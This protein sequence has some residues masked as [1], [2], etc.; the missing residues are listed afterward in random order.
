MEV[1]T[2]HGYSLASDEASIITDESAKPAYTKSLHQSLLSLQDCSLHRHHS[3]SSTDEATQADDSSVVKSLPHCQGSKSVDEASMGATLHQNSTFLNKKFTIPIH[4][5]GWTLTE[6]NIL[7]EY[8]GLAMAVCAVGL[9]RNACLAS[10]T[11]NIGFSKDATLSII[12][13][14]ALAPLELLMQSS[15]AEAKQGREIQG[16][17]D[18]VEQSRHLQ[19]INQL[20]E[21]LLELKRLRS[22]DGKAN[23]R[24]VSIFASKEQAWKAER[25]KFRD[26]Q[27]MLCQELQ[28]SYLQQEALSLKLEHLRSPQK[29]PC[30]ECDHREGLF[31]AL[32]GRL[33][34]QEFLI[35]ATME[36]AQIE[37]QEK[38][39]LAEKLASV[40]SSLSQM[41]EKLSVEAERHALELK[42]HGEFKELL[43]IK[44]KEAEI[45]N[46]QVSQELRAAQASISTLIHE[47]TCCEEHIADMSTEVTQLK[48]SV[49][50][51]DDI[52]SAMFKKAKADNEDRKELERELAIMKVK[53]FH[54]EKEKEKWR[55]LAEANTRSSLKTENFRS[56]SG[57]GSRPV[58]NT[59]EMIE[60]LQKLHDV[61]VKSLQ[62]TYEEQV[63]M[64]QKRLSLYQERVADLEEDILSR[65]TDA[66][67]R[68]TYK[69]HDSLNHGE[70]K[71]NKC[72]VIFKES[73][74]AELAT[75]QFQLSVAKTLIKQFMDSETH[76]EQEIENWKN[77]YLASKAA[78]GVHKEQEH[79]GAIV[80]K[81]PKL[82][83]RLELEKSR[84]AF[85][86]EQRH[87]QEIDAFERQMKA[88]DERMEAFRWQ[89]LHMEDEVQMCHR[90]IEDLKQSLENANEENRRLEE[91]L[92]QEEDEFLACQKKLALV[93]HTKCA[94]DDDHERE[95]CSLQEK[96]SVLE[97]LLT[98][99]TMEYERSL[100]RASA[101]AES[102]L[103]DRESKLAAAE[104]QLIQARISF[105]TERKEKEKLLLELQKEKSALELYFNTNLNSE[106]KKDLQAVSCKACLALRRLSTRKHE[107]QAQAS[108]GDNVDE[109][110]VKELVEQ[111]AQYSNSNLGVASIMEEPGSVS[112]EKNEKAYV[113]GK[114]QELVDD[115]LTVDKFVAEV[116]PSVLV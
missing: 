114:P 76:R 72:M 101:E 100:I 67:H 104:A 32:K 28:R 111:S 53:L 1:L 36:E 108:P 74:D 29:Q 25:R 92:K 6:D 63:R 37:Q 15:S 33:G 89:L 73:M 77:L 80:P 91:L 50:G 107:A 79:A 5:T 60:E 95:V 68:I 48:R 35:M 55:R 58:P 17:T 38:N 49:Q 13:Q 64:L 40:E 11:P 81:N 57:F 103:Q 112:K 19:K 10:E 59:T 70:I 69:E 31:A 18:K 102:E 4:V 21:E 24:V 52:I 66:K 116:R 9:L 7:G 93:R 83:D 41:H 75:K 109:E 54:A 2:P 105:D 71:D 14:D 26:D 97:A 22:E 82:Q 44:I 3:F 34:E 78:T 30:S 56:R 23:E 88:R 61:E 84:Y 46:S 110:H 47:K 12:G 8:F 99:K 65:L 106:T 39:A 98:E 42:A 115:G 45:E 94:C 90:Q 16:A 43:Q 87:W 51:K 96:V 62:S 20:Q 27:Q 86:L 85:K 113:S